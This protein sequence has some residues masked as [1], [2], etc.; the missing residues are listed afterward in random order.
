MEAARERERTRR[1]AEAVQAYIDAGKSFLEDHADAERATLAFDAAAKL[2][3][4]NVEVEYQRGIM[5]AIHGR[6]REALEKFLN[7][8]RASGQSHVPAMFEAG[9]MYQELGQFDN[10]VLAFRRVLDRDS[11]NVQALVNVARRLQAMGM[12]PEALNHYLAAAETAIERGQRGTGRHLLGLIQSMDPLHAKARLL[13]AELNSSEG[14]HAEAHV[15]AVPA[16]PEAPKPQAVVP[17]HVV[18]IQELRAERDRL[19][20]EL[21]TLAAAVA[22]EETELASLRAKREAAA[23]VLAELQADVERRAQLGDIAASPKKR[24]PRTKKTERV[25]RE[26]RPLQSG[27]AKKKT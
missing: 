26:G 13:L 15:E 27:R 20:A 17:G 24:A 14:A 22:A 4:N 12:R 21:Q 19:R 25:D 6:Q 3:P 2:D 11:G 9:C 16:A 1:G 18:E 8:V 7:V 5:D 10:A 23:K